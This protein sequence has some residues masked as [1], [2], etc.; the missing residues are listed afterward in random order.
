M[1]NFLMAYAT[2][3]F[4]VKTMRNVDMIE[5]ESVRQEKANAHRRAWKFNF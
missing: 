4:V 3:E 1:K 5:R 2:L